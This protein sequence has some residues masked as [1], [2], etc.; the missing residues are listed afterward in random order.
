MGG[1]FQ[2]TPQEV[3]HRMA[4]W[5]QTIDGEVAAPGNLTCRSGHGRRTI[6]FFIVDSRITQGVKGVWVQFD[7]PSSPHYAVVLRIEII[8]ADDEFLKVIVPKHF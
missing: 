5:L 2:N 8:A 7:F 1:D 3:Q 6:V 4:K